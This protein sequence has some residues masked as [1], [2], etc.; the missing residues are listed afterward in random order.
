MRY[1][2]FLFTVLTSIGMVGRIPLSLA[3]SE[4]EKLKIIFSR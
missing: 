1:K 3:A 2:L 4:P